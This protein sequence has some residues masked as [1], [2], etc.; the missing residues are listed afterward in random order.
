MDRPGG[1]AGQGAFAE[2]ALADQE[3]A[4]G[5][6]PVGRR[7]QSIQQS[8]RAVI[9]LASVA[10][11]RFLVLSGTSN[12]KALALAQGNRG[13]A[14]SRDE[15]SSC[16][17]LLPLTSGTTCKQ[18]Y[19]R[20][21]DKSGEKRLTMHIPAYGLALLLDCLFC[22][23]TRNIRMLKLKCS[24]VLE[25]PGQGHRL[26]WRFGSTGLIARKEKRKR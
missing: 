4:F 5:V 8:E 18:P 7:E 22:I 21:K 2:D 26:T 12:R 15:N 10:A 19:C 17:R 23:S 9:V 24:Q 14:A 16:M 25:G 13:R 20:H 3:S 6:R 11:H 1:R